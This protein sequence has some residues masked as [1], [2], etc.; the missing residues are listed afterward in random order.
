MEKLTIKEKEYL[1]EVLEDGSILLIPCDL[2]N[3]DYQ[4]YLKSLEL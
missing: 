2:A 3:A 4:A 1:H